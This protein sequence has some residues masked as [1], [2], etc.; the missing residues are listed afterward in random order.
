MK[1]NLNTKLIPTIIVSLLASTVIFSWIIIQDVSTVL[2]QRF[3]K[4]S[5]SD[6]IASHALLNEYIMDSSYRTLALASLASTKD[7][8]KAGNVASL[9]AAAEAIV[10]NDD[11]RID[12]IVFLSA[13]GSILAEVSNDSKLKINTEGKYSLKNQAKNGLFGL[14]ETL[15]IH[16][17]QPVILNGVVVGA[18]ITGSDVFSDNTFVTRLKDELSIEST[19]VLGNLRVGTTLVNP[20]GESLRGTRLLNESLIQKVQVEGKTVNDDNVSFPGFRSTF[21]SIYSPLKDWEGKIIGLLYVGVSSEERSVIIN[22][23]IK[24]AVMIVL[25]SGIIFGLINFLLIRTILIKPIRV[26]TNLCDRLARLDLSEDAH[27]KSSDELGQLADS[28]NTFVGKIREVM[29]KLSEQAKVVGQSSEELATVAKAMQESTTQAGSKIKNTTADVE[30]MNKRSFTAKKALEEVSSNIITVSSSTEE[31]TATIGEIANNSSN[32]RTITAEATDA[33]T[34]ASGM[35]KDLGEAAQEISTVTESISNISAQT[36]ILALNATIEAARA[37][38]AG[39]GF[40]VVANE[41]KNLA[42]ETESAT[43]NIHGKVNDIQS[44]THLA[45]DNVESVTK[46]INDVNSI[47]TSIAA[48]IEE[49]SSVT[50]DISNNIGS[51]S[52][53]IQSSSTVMTDVYDITKKVNENISQVGQL[54][55]GISSGNTQIRSS[56][57][58]L[59]VLAQELKGSVEQF[60][61]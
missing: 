37:G 23:I 8:V 52:S 12:T 58:N 19:V 31:M 51:I 14:G 6:N 20:A 44:S 18:V 42:Q 60:K 57:D 49:Q 16:S 36:N 53:N 47:V 35:I 13:D 61:L 30:E 33:A 21:I 41:I 50:K 59:A 56:A 7:D 11:T 22:G 3:H 25:A 48:A 10:K 5:S 9:K 43:G 38:A 27:I 55:E 17:E 45:V 54:A 2:T 32:A 26:L 4:Q 28:T 1:L 29:G 34:K 40:A 39:K 15:Y 24:T 46:V